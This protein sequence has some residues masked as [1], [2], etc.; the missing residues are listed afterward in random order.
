MFDADRQERIAIFLQFAGGRNALGGVKMLRVL[1]SDVWIT[2]SRTHAK[3]TWG[4][5]RWG[6]RPALAGTSHFTVAIQSLRRQRQIYNLFGMLVFPDALRSEQTDNN[7]TTTF[8]VSAQYLLA[9][10]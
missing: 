1:M 3:P 4:L 8:E 2:V 6:G 5:P 7:A 10:L 9:D